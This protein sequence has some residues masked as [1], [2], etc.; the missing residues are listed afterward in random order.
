MNF[1]AVS[2]IN[3]NQNLA[4]IATSKGIDFIPSPYTELQYTQNKKSVHYVDAQDGTTHKKLMGLHEQFYKELKSIMGFKR[5]NDTDF[6]SLFTKYKEFR[7]RKY[8][9]YIAFAEENK[10]KLDNFLEISRELIP[11]NNV[12]DD[13]AKDLIF[14]GGAFDSDRA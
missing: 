14:V 6:K 9:A 2:P 3:S 8:N 1:L 11:P 5:N 10:E 13:F 7:W 12:A 4:Q